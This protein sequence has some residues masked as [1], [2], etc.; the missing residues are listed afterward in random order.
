ML[1]GLSL[2]NCCGDASTLKSTCTKSSISKTKYSPDH[3][4][5]GLHLYPSRI[6]QASLGA[7]LDGVHFVGEGLK[8]T[9][10]PSGNAFPPQCSSVIYRCCQSLLTKCPSSLVPVVLRLRKVTNQTAYGH[11]QAGNPAWHNNRLVPDMTVLFVDSAN[12]FV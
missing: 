7:A 4:S 9:P 6:P 5:P 11:Q 10:Q 8:N 12:P 3:R 1:C 2:L